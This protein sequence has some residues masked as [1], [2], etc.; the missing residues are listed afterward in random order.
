MR[1]DWFTY[2][3]VLLPV[4]VVF[5]ASCEEPTSPEYSEALPAI[6][7]PW[8]AQQSV[9][10]FG[11][12]LTYG[13]MGQQ[14]D[15]P[16][17]PQFS[18]H[19]YQMPSSPVAT[20]PPAYAYPALLD[21]TLR[22]KVYNQGQ[23]GATTQRALQIVADSVFR[24]NPA[25]VLLEFG[26]NDFLQHIRD[27]L[28]EQRLGKLMD[29]LRSYGSKVIFISFLNPE[30]I[31]LLPS[32]HFL[33]SRR[34]E[35]PIVLEMLRRVASSHAVLFVEYA[36]RGIYWNPGL[37]SDEVHPNQAG[38]RR[39]QQNISRALVNTFQKNGMLK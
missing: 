22:I 30:M 39:M 13:F 23:V 18:R 37:M 1:P 34:H 8:T 31:A 26:A 24:L 33:Y 11:T 17:D 19:D 2:W 4:I 21:S 7:V 38:Y 25:L 36:M 12:S 35:A 3:R 32:N 10:C 9:V 6:D 27:S 16:A 14:F 20:P 28:V 29:T 5:F 15:R